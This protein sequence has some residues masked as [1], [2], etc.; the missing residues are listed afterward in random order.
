MPRFDA[1]TNGGSNTLASISAASERCM[2]WYPDPIAP[3]L[4]EKNAFALVRTPGILRFCTLPQGPVRGVW[5]GENRLFAAGGSHLY[6]VLANTTT[7]DHGS[8]GNDGNPVQFFSNGNQLFVVSNGQAYIDNGSGATA[9]QFS[10][11]LTDLVI[12]AVT[13]GLTGP[14]GGIFDASDVGNQVQMVSGTGFIINRKAITSVVNGQA[15]AATSWGTDGSTGGIGIEWLYTS[16]SP[17]LVGA[18]QGAFLDG[19]FFAAAANSKQVFFSAINDGTSWNPLDFF[20]KESY[21]DNCQSI[22]ADHEE[23]YVFGD[24]ESS[25]VFQDTGAPP[26]STPFQPDPGAIMH[27]GCA[28]RYSVCRLGEGLAFLGGDVRRGDRVAFLAVGFR[29]RRIS[30]SAQEVAWAAYSTISD[31]VS[32][33]YIDRGH[34]YWV[35]NF[36]TGNAT[37]VYDLTTD[38]WAERGYWTGGFD[39]NG[40]PTWNRQR[41]AF[42]AV[43]AFVAGSTEK[44]YV[45]DWQNGN[46]YVQSETYLDDDGTAIYRMRMAP[47]LTTENKRGYYFRWEIDCDVTGLQR[48]YWNRLGMGRDRIWAMVSWQTQSTGVSMKLW[49]SNTRAQTWNTAGGSVTPNIKTLAV[50][51]DVTLANAYLEVAQG[52]T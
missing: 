18:V 27:Y 32:Y 34:E 20:T 37:W 17:N 5:P 26:P 52:Y 43:V 8:I 38:K 1:F 42:H 13:H 49:Y 29:P 15:F 3:G 25:E 28:A 45:G 11:A 33:S 23:L 6:E 41:Q 50:G 39:A 31:A 36:P 35:I 46:I 16:G 19:Y 48:V 14:T 51:V 7:V 22:Q 47:H 12:D 24:L 4:P 10:I 21:P 2:N 40:L 44:H 9:I 30:T